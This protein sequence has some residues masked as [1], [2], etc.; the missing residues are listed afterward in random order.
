MLGRGL[1]RAGRPGLIGVAARSA[2]AA[3]TA[4]AVSHRVAHREAERAAPAPPAEP[5]PA[6]EPELLTDE[7]ISSLERLGKLHAQG[8][9]SDEEFALGKDRILRR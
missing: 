2:V 6:P 4:T 5:M 7:A 1:R 3:G 9:L 8:V